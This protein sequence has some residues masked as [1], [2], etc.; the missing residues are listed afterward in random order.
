[1]AEL[2]WRRRSKRFTPASYTANETTALFNVASGD[3]I[4]PVFA[5]VAT[6][7]DGTGGRTISLGDD[8]DVDRFM[9]TTVGD[10]STAAV[11]T[12]VGGTGTNY[13]LIGQHLYTAADTIDVVFTAATGGSPTAGVVVVTIYV[14][15]LSL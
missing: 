8:S 3:L 1:M 12:G 4:G 15:K 2:N 10:V 11:L 7:F 6:A 5:R 14:A 13:L 9:T